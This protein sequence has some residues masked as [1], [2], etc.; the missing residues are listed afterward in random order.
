MNEEKKNCTLEEEKLD[1]VTGGLVE[2]RE[3]DPYYQYYLK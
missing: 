2:R 3:G 1:K